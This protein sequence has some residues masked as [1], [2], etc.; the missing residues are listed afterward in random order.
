MRALDGSGAPTLFDT[1]SLHL[2][3]ELACCAAPEPR[4]PD[5]SLATGRSLLHLDSNLCYAD[6]T[7]HLAAAL[8]VLHSASFCWQSLGASLENGVKSL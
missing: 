5:L 3:E 6:Q 1:I 7:P 2:F 8:S 4:K